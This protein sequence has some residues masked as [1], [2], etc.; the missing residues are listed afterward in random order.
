ME[1]S[2]YFPLVMTNMIKIG[3]K[4]GS[5]E[6]SLLKVADSYDKEVERM[7]R[8]FTTLIEPIL[9]LS[10]GLVVGCVVI[11]MLLPIFNI[12]LAVK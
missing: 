5:V 7:T 2:P 12:N 10:L 6:K 11:S 3:E 1:E 9:I 8:A 4:S